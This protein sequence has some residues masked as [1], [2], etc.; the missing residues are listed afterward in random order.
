[1]GLRTSGLDHTV[2]DGPDAKGQK[3]GRNGSETN[4]AKTGKSRP[5]DVVLGQVLSVHVGENLRM[6]L[7]C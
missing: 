4:V 7:S 2:L 5:E 6:S 1:M 3:P